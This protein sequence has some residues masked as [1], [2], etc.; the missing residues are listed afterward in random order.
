MDGIGDCPRGGQHGNLTHAR[1]S[2][3]P[4]RIRF[5][6][7]HWYN[8]R[9]IQDGWDEKGGQRL[10][11][12][13]A[14]KQQVLFHGAVALTHDEPALDLTFYVDRVH[15]PADVMGS[16]GPENLHLAGIDIHLDLHHLG[17]VGV[18]IIRPGTQSG[19]RIEGRRRRG[20]VGVF[21]HDRQSASRRIG[22]YGRQ[23]PFCL[24]GCPHHG[25]ASHKGRSRG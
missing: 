21:D 9:D 1:G 10:G 20:M 25:I 5:F 6:Q 17:T 12:G 23:F 3:R 19:F 15:R 24:G 11:L 22:A 8:L 7:D 13:L 18:G 14:V 16:H 4:I 2:G